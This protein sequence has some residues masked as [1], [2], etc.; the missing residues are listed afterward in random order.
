M[1]KL[2]PLSYRWKVFMPLIIG[3][4]VLII[5]LAIWQ[6]YRE[7]DFRR[8]YVDTQLEMVNQRVIDALQSGKTDIVSDYLEFVRRYYRDSPNLSDIR[9]TLFDRNWN[10]MH[11]M[12]P[13]ILL[14]KDDRDDV[15]DHI[16]QRE[17]LVTS[18]RG[19]EFLYRG[20]MPRDGEHIVV[21]SIPVND[22]M[23]KALAG[24][25]ETIW[26]II[27]GIAVLMT[28]G[29]YYS[30]RYFA[31]NIALLREFARRSASDPDF[32]P[33]T[34]FPRDEIGDIARE[35]VTIYNER[36][37]ARRRLDQ[38]HQ[39][40]MKAIEEKSLQKRQMTNNINHELKTP[41]GVIKGYLDTLVEDPDLD[42][43]VRDHFIRKARDHANRLA[44]LIAEV[45]AITRLAEGGNMINTENIDMH[46]FV[47]QFAND[48]NDSGALGHMEFTFDVPIGTMVR[49]NPTLLQGV[50]MN[51]AKNAA[52]YSCGTTCTLECQ[53]LTGDG[54]MYKFSFWDDGVGVPEDSLSH[55]FERFYR[56]DT[57]RSRK[58]GGTGLG[59]PIV[60]NTITAHGG[61]ITGR[62]HPEGGLEIAFTL[63][64]AAKTTR[65]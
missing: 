22:N 6:T 25:R 10:V 26:T 15:L 2:K 51:L 40:A 29:L 11:A 20:G 46:D 45:S 38:E 44:D 1:S 39:V 9:I 19:Q 57:G 16:I 14:D 8:N 34:D 31:S 13:P 48:I 27:I 30:S 4:W 36:A 32:S 42:P 53:G 47:Y 21:S 64:R 60:Y 41:I 63:P 62:N 5:G 18:L 58:N 43:E 49:A 12:G 65:R 37:K 55:L 52:N 56:V 28:I 17:A 7:D 59:L 61:T 33:G 50:L 54:T 35:I 24:D 3:L 23:E